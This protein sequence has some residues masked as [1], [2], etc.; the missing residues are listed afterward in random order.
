VQ[1]KKA[2]LA[3][4]SKTSSKKASVASSRGWNLLRPALTN[5][6]SIRP[7]ARDGREELADLRRPADIDRDGDNVVTDRAGGV[8]EPLPVPPRDRDLGALLMQPPGGRQA[9]AAATAGHHRDG[10]VKPAHNC[11]LRCHRPV[12]SPAYLLASC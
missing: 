8:A 2:P 3:L 10:A 5:S 11:R 6:T 1:V 12:T 7:S 4:T 9:D